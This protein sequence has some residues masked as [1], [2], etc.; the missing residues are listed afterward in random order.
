MYD[1][2]KLAYNFCRLRWLQ[3]GNKTC[4]YRFFQVL[5]TALNSFLLLLLPKCKI[6]SI[7][8]EAHIGGVGD[9]DIPATV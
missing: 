2:S 1:N 5:F 8:S 7:H 4:K 3:K 9:K 6:D